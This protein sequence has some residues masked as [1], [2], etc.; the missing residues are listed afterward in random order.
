MKKH[1]LTATFVLLLLLPLAYANEQFG[2]ENGKGTTQD[3]VGDA[4]KGKGHS[5]VNIFDINVN[6][7]DYL[8]IVSVENIADSGVLFN[9]DQ[10]QDGFYGEI[11][12]GCIE[13]IWFDS[14]L[15]VIKVVYAGKCGR[16]ARD[17]HGAVEGE[18]GLAIGS[19]K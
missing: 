17:Y 14:N 15:E 11:Y 8:S 16:T 13:N 1:I 9:Q 18:K 19:R 3:T 5:G 2:R 4:N 12:E 10:L 6:G 7:Q